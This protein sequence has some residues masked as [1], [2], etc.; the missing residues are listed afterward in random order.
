M[1]ITTEVTPQQICDMFITAVEGGSAYWCS[2]MTFHKQGKPANYQ[3]EGT[4]IG[5]V[6][7]VFVLPSEKPD[8]E[9]YYQ[10][11]PS[12]LALAFKAM[13]VRM[14][15]VVDGSYDADDADALIQQAAFGDIVFG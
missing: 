4:F 14:N 7:H 3:H 6:W 11:T 13:P 10:I 9:P 1:Q 5:Y 15:A 2:A 8:D 12:S